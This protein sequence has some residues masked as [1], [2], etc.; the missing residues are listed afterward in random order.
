MI[1]VCVE[2]Q[3]ESASFRVAVRAESIDRAVGIAK[4]RYPGRAARVVFPIDS[5]EF[6][7][8]R[9]GQD[10]IGQPLHGSFARA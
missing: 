2:V 9:L 3:E 5:E 6:F 7:Q 1:K 10:E 8:D 4:G